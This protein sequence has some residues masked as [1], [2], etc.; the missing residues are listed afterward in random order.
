MSNFHPLGVVDRRSKTQPHVVE[1]LNKL[2]Q[3]DVIVNTAHTLLN[4]SKVNYLTAKKP[5]YIC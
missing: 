5:E 2:T 4:D 3:Q 1:N